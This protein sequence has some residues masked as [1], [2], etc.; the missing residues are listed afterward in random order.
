LDKGLNWILGNKD[1]TKSS[2]TA[3]TTVKDSVASH[4][5]SSLD[6]GIFF[7]DYYEKRP[8]AI[9]RQPST[10]NYYG[11]LFPFD[12]CSSII[13]HWPDQ[14]KNDD[15]VIVNKNFVTPIAY[16]KL[17]EY[18]NAYL[19][20]NTL[21]MF[22]LNRLYP[23]LGEL[24]DD[25]D[26]DFGFPWRVNLYLTPKGAKGFLPHTDQHDFFI[27]QT[28]GKKKWRV[29]NNPIPLNTR[30][31]EQ[32]KK[33]GKALNE[34]NLGSPLLEV[35]LNQGDALYVPRGYIHVAET[36]EDTGSLH[37]TV[38]GTNSFFF[39]MG[40]VFNAILPKPKKNLGLPML[41]V[42]QELD[43]EFRRSTP[44]HMLDLKDDESANVLL[45]GVKHGGDDI[46]LCGS[47]KNI[48]SSSTM[49]QCIMNKRWVDAFTRAGDKYR[50][51]SRGGIV[52]TSK[53]KIKKW[54]KENSNVKEGKE[55]DS[56]FFFFFVF[57]SSL[58]TDDLFSSK[59]IFFLP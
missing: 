46:G 2:S 31:Q 57:F 9:V 24:V 25:L 5:Y 34:K 14:R 7:R 39:N 44:V 21:G 27:L 43:V 55:V 28:G 54:F 19:Q 6:R 3:T 36:F 56:F 32:G 53:I 22:I 59:T 17:P 45:N 13:D 12:A 50:K 1:I 58:V 10:A 42:L 26:R 35:V 11:N 38:R 15:W 47:T 16:S 23:T 41:S 20:G 30:K 33:A 52:R 37:L 49:K 18:Y 4:I 40:H 48:S 8:L 29:Y 51:S